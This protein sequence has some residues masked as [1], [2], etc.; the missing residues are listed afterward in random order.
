MFSHAVRA[1][2]SGRVELLGMR[3][4]LL[5]GTS[6]DYASTRRTEMV[7]GTNRG[8]FNIYNPIYGLL[9]PPGRVGADA[10]S[11]QTERLETVAFYAQDAIHLD[12][13]WILVAGMRYQHYDQ[14]AGKG[15]PFSLNTDVNDG[16]FVPHLGLVYRLT[17]DISLYGTYS[18][19]FKPNSST[20]N[21]YGAQPLETGESWEIGAKFDL[22]DGLTATVSGFHTVKQ[23]VLYRY[24]IGGV[25]F[26]AT[27][28]EVRSRGVEVDF[29]GRITPQLS[30]IGS[31]AFTDAEVTDDPEIKGN[32]PGL[33]PRNIPSLFLTCDFGQA[34]G[35]EGLHAGF[36]GRYMGSRQGDRANSF[37]LPSYEVFDA[38]AA[39]DTRIQDT[40][41]RL[42]VN[43]RNIFDKTFY[44]SSIGTNL[45]VAVG[46]PLQVIASATV[47]F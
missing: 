8:G 5:F 32:R 13:Q 22:L 16:R 46:E 15:R 23:N 11:E 3:H 14:I 26:N 34:L 45:G 36:G 29:A 20:A 18:Q 47:R 19:S 39:Y 28:G 37:Q 21:A 6:Y 38:F 27:A 9:P 2:L 31:Y 1:D 24:E 41:L 42:Q 12:D 35:S 40:P 44:T 10:D 7:R 4:D 17:P 30:V 33:V 25:S 43:V